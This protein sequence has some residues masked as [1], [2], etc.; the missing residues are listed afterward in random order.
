MNRRHLLLAGMAGALGFSFVLPASAANTAE[1]FVSGNIQQGFDILNDRGTSAAQRKARFATFVVGLTDVKRVAVFLLGRYA[2]AAAPADMDAYVAAYQDYVLE[3]YQSYFAQYAG[4]SLRIIDSRERATNDFVV[5]TNMTGNS[6]A[7]IE[8]DFRVRTDGAKPVLVDLGV[9]GV[10]L[11][12]AQ[13]DQFTAVL[14]QNNGD[15]KALTAHLRSTE[16]LY[17]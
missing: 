17:R 7:P 16:K 10:W 8:I 12:L 3:V 6:A 4:Q 2:N 13:R 11:A 5:R 1:D 14:G 15:I 9:A